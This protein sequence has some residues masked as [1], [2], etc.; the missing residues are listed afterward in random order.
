MP[1]PDLVIRTSGEHRISNFLLWQL[2]YSELVFDDVLWPDFRRGPPLRR[3]RDFQRRQRRYGGVTR[4]P[5]GLT[6]SAATT[7]GGCGSRPA[8]WSGSLVYAGMCLM[9]VAG[10]T[11][12]RPLVVVPP[13]HGGTHRRQQPAR[14]GPRSPA[15]PAPGRAGPG[16]GSA[17]RRPDQRGRRTGAGPP[18]ATASRSP[19]GPR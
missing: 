11:G 2:A 10:F 16:A 1:D 18:G 3:R 12:G 15:D 14:R 9:D 19:P 17:G 7:P 5:A 6:T 4:C 8:S 13:V